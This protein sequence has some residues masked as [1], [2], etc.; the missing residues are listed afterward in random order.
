MPTWLF[1]LLRYGLPVLAVAGMVWGAYS[2]SWDRGFDACTTR[3]KA[4]V[5]EAKGRRDAELTVARLRGDA[6]SH[7]LAQKER[8]FSDLRAEY[9]IYANSI[10]GHCPDSLGVLVAAAATAGGMPPSAGQPTDPAATVAASLIAANIA[11]NYPRCHAA[12]AQLDALID[13]HAATKAPVK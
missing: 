3:W 8:Q 10:T 6:L 1:P 9:L 2:W 5:A 11:T 7:A 4:D 12:I 13:W